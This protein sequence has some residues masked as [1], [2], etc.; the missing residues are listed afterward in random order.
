MLG[1]L[2]IGKVQF[3]QSHV[4]S[5]WYM[6]LSKPDCVITRSLEVSIT[7]LLVQTE[8]REWEIV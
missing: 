2:A 3:D 6:R 5:L 7:L 8:C 1:R 4:S